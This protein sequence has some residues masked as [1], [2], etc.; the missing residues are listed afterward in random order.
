MR[1][2]DAEESIIFGIFRA[3]LANKLKHQ[4]TKVVVSKL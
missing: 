2:C 3:M 4:Q 1:T